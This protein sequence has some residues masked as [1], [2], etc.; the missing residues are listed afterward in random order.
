M[1][2]SGC[3]TIRYDRGKNRQWYNNHLKGESQEKNSLS[4]TAKGNSPICE[5]MSCFKMWK[6]GRRLCGED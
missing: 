5:I 3:K 6:V 4:D 1:G 2:L